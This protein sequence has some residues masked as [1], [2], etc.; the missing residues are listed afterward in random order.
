MSTFDTRVPRRCSLAGAVEVAPPVSAL[1]CAR[2]PSLLV[3][4]LA[5][6]SPALLPSHLGHLLDALFASDER[7]VDVV[8]RPPLDRVA[9][10][11]ALD[12]GGV[13]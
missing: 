10:E 13:G 5:A 12:P 3:R 7:E 2:T 11:A 6:V 9:R 1:P 8:A 4:R